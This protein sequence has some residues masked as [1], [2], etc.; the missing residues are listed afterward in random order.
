MSGTRSLDDYIWR[1]MRIAGGTLLTHGSIEENVAALKQVYFQPLD[2]LH[3]SV[4]ARAGRFISFANYDY[5]GLG[6]DP[7]VRRAAADAAL[8]F[9]VGAEASRLVGGSR[10]VHDLL[11]RE[12]AEFLSVEDAVTLVSG[13]MTNASLLGYLLT[14]SDLIVVD[15]LAHNSIVVGADV[16][17]ARVLSFRHGN[18]DDLEALLAEHRPR[19]KRALIV[20]EGLYSMDGDMPDLGRVVELKRKYDAWLMVDEAHSIGVLGATGRGITEHFGIDPAEIDFTIGTLSKTFAASGG[21]IAG[22][23]TVIEW[24]RFTLPASMFSVG[25]SPVIAAAVREGL[26][27]LRS[28]PWRTARVQDNSRFFIEEARARDL[29]VGPAVGAGVVSIQFPSYEVCM[30]AAERLLRAGYYAPP[31]PIM[32]VPKNKP[33]IRFFI[34]ARH[35]QTDIVGAL[36]EVAA[37]M[38]EAYRGE[39]GCAAAVPGLRLGT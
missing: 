29:N 38:P 13:W 23:K 8:S 9:G 3:E 25:L 31:I 26:S 17:H 28:E 22:R 2:A 18:L 20:V 10:T 14:R 19:A 16:S 12:I 30:H 36:D 21:F 4:K 35:N 32:A 6:E 27:I 15:E 39:A 37:A 11:E 7:R 5:L 34:S 1:R 33:R 24:L